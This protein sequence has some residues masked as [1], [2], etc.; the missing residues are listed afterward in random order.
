ML[1][2]I[3]AAVAAPSVRPVSVQAAADG[4]DL[5]AFMS[6]VLAR[7]DENW[8]KLQQYVLDED[9]T[10][11]LTGPDG[12]RLFGTHR[13]Y[14][15]FPRDGIFVRSPTRADGVTISEADRRKAEDEWLRGEKQR[16]ERRQKRA[17][18]KSGDDIEVHVDDNAVPGLDDLVKAGNE[19]R[20]ISSAYFM[21]FKFDP[22]HYAL[23][24]REQLLGKDVLRIEYYPSRLFSEGRTRPN[25]ELRKRDDEIDEKMNKVALV[26][27]WVEPAEHQILQYQFRNIDFDFLPARYLVRLDQLQAS[28]R[29]GQPF[30]GVWLPD[31][32]AMR[33]AMSI[34][35][36]SIDAR[37]DVR[38]HDYRLADVKTRVR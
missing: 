27:L 34:A 15:W 4:N 23:A 5:D 6:Q 19:P 35:I 26:T 11:L 20:F 16:E 1:A 12:K 29:M 2:A 30:P 10:F 8:K 13:E 28:M 9:E 33:F 32:I 24:G 25:K 18:Q 31:T 22:G 17:S 14:N 38:Y 7:R 36:G 3:V 37:Y 21:R